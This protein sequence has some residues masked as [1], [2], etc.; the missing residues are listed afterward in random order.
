MN[1]WINWGKKV[2]GAQGNSSPFFFIAVNFD[3]DSTVSLSYFFFLPWRA[4]CQAALFL[5]T[6][7]LPW[8]LPGMFAWKI[9]GLHGN[10][11][12]PSATT[13][14]VTSGMMKRGA[15]EHRSDHQT[16][17]NDIHNHPNQ[18]PTAQHH[19][20]PQTPSKIPFP[21]SNTTSDPRKTPQPPLHSFFSK[22]FDAWEIACFSPYHWQACFEGGF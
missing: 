9:T 10:G 4:L 14:F 11:F 7:V 15:E 19:K 21:T 2:K 22:H 8:N 12:F 3:K 13:P 20:N 1:V 6:M 18:A 5:F 17:Q 16:L